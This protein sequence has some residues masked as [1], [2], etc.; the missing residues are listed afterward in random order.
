MAHGRWYAHGIVLPDGRIMAFS[1]YNETGGIDNQV[2]FY[3][4]G[5]G[6]SSPLTAPFSPNLYPWLHVLTEGRVFNSGG[7]PNSN[8]F[9]PSIVPPNQPWTVNFTKTSTG[10]NRTYGNSVLLPLL[11]PNYAARVMILGGGVPNATATTEIIDF[12]KPTPAWVKTIDLMPSGA[13]V[14]GNSVLL[15]NGKVLVQGGSRVN[16]DATTAT[17]GADLFDPA[18]GKWLPTKSG[19]PTTPGGAGFAKFARLDHS[20]ALLIPAA[21]VGTT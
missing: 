21:T 16:N 17:L 20:V 18:I 1:G 11:P 14:E 10:L 2:E 6:W 13:R 12:S 15:P 4:V 8:M 9:D 5:S 19:V 3:T 7:S